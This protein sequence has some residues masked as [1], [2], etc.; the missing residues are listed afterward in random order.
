MQENDLL[1]LKV[2]DPT[3]FDLDIIPYPL[4]PDWKREEYLMGAQ[5]VKIVHYR[6]EKSDRRRPGHLQFTLGRRM[7]LKDTDQSQPY[8]VW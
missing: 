2:K 8:T 6:P 1:A 4:N 3:T 5:M 7:G